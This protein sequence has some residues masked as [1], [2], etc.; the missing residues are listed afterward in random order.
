GFVTGA[1]AKVNPSQSGTLFPLNSCTVDAVGNSMN[2]SLTLPSNAPTGLY[3]V[4]VTNPDNQ[5][6][7]LFSAFTVDVPPAVTQVLPPSGNPGQSLTVRILGSNFASG[8]LAATVTFGSKDILP[9]GPPTFVPP[10]A[11]ATEIDVAIAIN[12][13]AQVQPAI[14]VTV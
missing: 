11:P 6:G 8:R 2:C 9:T 13:T 3:D 1:T 4:T 10:T 12:A 7:T 5:S 14:D